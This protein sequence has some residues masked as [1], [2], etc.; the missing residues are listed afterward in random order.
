MYDYGL[1]YG[2]VPLIK[3][4]FAPTTTGLNSKVVL[5]RRPNNIEH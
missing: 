2:E 3:P 4:P 5:I 1:K